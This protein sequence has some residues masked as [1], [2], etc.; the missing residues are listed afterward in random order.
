M[1]DRIHKILLVDDDA[2]TRG[3][4]AEVFKVS[5]FETMEAE[6]GVDGL[7]KATKNMPDVIFT[8]IVM[9]RMDGFE[10]IEALKKNIMTCNVP[11]VIS[12]HLGRE[13]DRQRANML[14]V[15]DFI[16][17]DVTPP[18]EVVERV[19]AIF[20]GGDYKIDINPYNMDAPS[21]AGMLGVNKNFQC[22]E[23]NEKIIVKLKLLDPRDKKFEA[24]FVCPHCGWEA[25]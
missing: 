11:V 2:N 10:M 8:G 1:Q 4:Y 7:D 25:R 13:T 5:G 21:L 19:R 3:M 6:D 22:M 17:R 24:L 14:G 12:S 16:V 15:K 18:K 23:C 9:P 20:A